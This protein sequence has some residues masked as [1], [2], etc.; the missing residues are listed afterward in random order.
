MSDN[1]HDLISIIVPVFKAEQYL[2]RCIDSILAQTY[3]HYEII[4]VDDDSPDRCPQICDRYAAEYSNMFAIHLKDTKAGVSDARNAG[5]SQTNGKYVAFIDSDD[6]VPSKYLEVL[7]DTIYRCKSKLSMCPYKIVH[8]YAE[9]VEPAY[10]KKN[11]AKII[12]D[13]EAME[14]LL[15]DQAYSAPWGKLYERSLFNDMEYPPGKFNEDMFTAPILFRKAKLIG[16][17]DQTL[18]FYNQEGESLIRTAFNYHKLGMIDASYFWK[19][20]AD[21]HY[22]NLSDRAFSAYLSTI[23]NSCQYIANKTDEYGKQKYI[24]YQS[25]IL[26]K[27][28]YI[29][30]STYVTRNNK[31]KVLLLKYGMFKTIIRLIQKFNIR[32][33]DVGF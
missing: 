7:I 22:P 33:Y 15:V 16:F 12:N 5:L 4:L 19:E 14:M 32:K 9:K 27:F 2:K 10:D 18:Y 31:L 20:L 25:I 13:N 24:E 29:I 8:S 1:A 30:H 23:I 17:S 26:D 3:T 6:F 21:L 28:K 11:I